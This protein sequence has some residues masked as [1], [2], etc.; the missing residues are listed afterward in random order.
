MAPE[1]EVRDPKPEEIQQKIE[2]TRSALT[3]K[4][5]TL[6]N[7]VR[8]TVQNVT[9]TVEDTIENVKETVH[10]TVQ[11]VKRTFDLN[12]Q[13][14][15]HPWGMVG[16][17]FA[18]GLVSA[19]LLQGARH[20]YYP[21]RSYEANLGFQSAP[22][23]TARAAEGPSVL[24]WLANQFQPELEKVKEMAIGAAIGFIRDAVKQSVPP[25]MTNQI[26]E[27]FDSATQKLGGRPVSGPILETPHHAVPPGRAAW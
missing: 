22:H 13:V 17:S 10:E 14:D 12:Y 21:A 16:L 7:E 6:E 4:L 5:E 25:S 1:P 11:T 20:R 18:S 27:V 26:S 15:R 8:G 2:E 24:G 19:A 3:E 9:S 23:S